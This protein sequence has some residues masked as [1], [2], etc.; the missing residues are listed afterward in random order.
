[1]S[2]RE[3]LRLRVYRRAFVWYGECPLCPGEGQR[4]RSGSWL[5]TFGAAVEHVSG[6]RDRI[7]EDLVRAGAAALTAREKA[8]AE[9]SAQGITNTDLHESPMSA[10]LFWE[11]QEEFTSAA[12]DLA[13]LLTAAGEEPAETA[14]PL[15]AALIGDHHQAMTGLDLAEAA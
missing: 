10:P 1:M 15:A 11:A 6:H 5:V 12:R 7:R 14:F 13:A 8:R 9:L 4:L 3:G 2:T